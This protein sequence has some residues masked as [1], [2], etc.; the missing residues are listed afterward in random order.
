M[1]PVDAA[2]APRDAIDRF[3]HTSRPPANPGRHHHRTTRLAS[4][5]RSPAPRVRPRHPTGSRL[6]G[7]QHPSHPAQTPA[8]ATLHP[9]QRRAHAAPP[10]CPPR[11]PVGRHGGQSRRR[12]RIPATSHRSSAQRPGPGRQPSLARQR[13]RFPSCSRHTGRTNPPH[14][15]PSRRARARKESPAHAPPSVV[16]P[17][18]GATD[19]YLGVDPG[20][21]VREPASVGITSLPRV[22]DVARHVDSLLA[23]DPRTRHEDPDDRRELPESPRHQ[24]FGRPWLRPLAVS[25]GQR[26]RAGKSYERLRLFVTRLN[27]S[28]LRRNSFS[29][30]ARWHDQNR[31]TSSDARSTILTRSP[32]ASTR[33]RWGASRRFAGS[34]R[35]SPLA[36][37]GWTGSRDRNRG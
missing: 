11:R 2:P 19:R 6:D 34:A 4:P 30:P 10:S 35:P 17:H 22:R 26:E 20:T 25:T 13:P 7:R 15:I 14:P 23:L 3:H 28:P 21:Q 1:K 9:A 12:C 27:L 24:C 31:S 36:A 8:P 29:T 37:Q 18:Q 5:A 16:P 33:D 32:T